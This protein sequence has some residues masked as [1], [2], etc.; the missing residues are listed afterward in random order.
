MCQMYSDIGTD[1]LA[2][3]VIRALAFGEHISKLVRAWRASNPTSANASVL[4]SILFEQYNTEVLSL[5]HAM[6]P[7]TMDSVLYHILYVDRQSQVKQEMVQTLARLGEASQLMMD[8]MVTYQ[9]PDV[10]TPDGKARGPRVLNHACFNG[11]LKA[12]RQ[13]L[14]VLNRLH[15]MDKEQRG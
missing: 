13:R 11:F 15:A 8:E 12:E 1:G 10:E 5:F 7:W 4:A 3:E 14:Q 9:A 2:D 6:Q